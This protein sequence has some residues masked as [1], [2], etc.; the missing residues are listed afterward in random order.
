MSVDAVVQR[1]DRFEA[2]AT[3]YRLDQR[4]S[5]PPSPSKIES[6][7][8]SVIRNSRRL[9]R[10]LG[11]DDVDAVM[12]GPTDPAFIA[13]LEYSDQSAD[14]IAGPAER[15]SRM[16]AVLEGI[17]AAADIEKAATG[18][19][20]S[21]PAFARK[22][23]HRG[24]RGDDPLNNWIEAMLVLYE[25]ITGRKPGTSVHPSGTPNRGKATGPLIRFLEA[26]GAPLGLSR[27]PDS[28]RERAR[29]VMRGSGSQN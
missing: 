16:I 25:E 15:L 11:I 20:P 29:L 2:A 26:A 1:V 5:R 24:H 3:W 17:Q 12:D 22:I 28:W 4:D 9:L 19:Y 14:G 10:G 18:A 7:L 8:D 21:A 6:K 23:T 13:A 27:S